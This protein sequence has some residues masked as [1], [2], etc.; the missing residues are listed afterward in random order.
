MAHHSRAAVMHH[1]GRPMELL[2]IRLADPRP[3]EVVVHTAI[4]GVCGTDL[5]FAAGRFP[6]PVPT[7]LGHEAAGTIAAVGD[8]VDHLTVGDRVIVCDQI[9]CGNCPACLS[10]SMVYCTDSG[11]K[12]R[13][14]ERLSLEGTSFRQYL[15]VSAFAEKLLVDAHACIPAP[16]D[17]PLDAAA[18]LSCCLTTGLAAV[19]NVARPAAGSRVAVIGCGGVGLG[20]VQAARI[21]GAAQIVAVDLEDHRLALAAEVGATDTVNAASTDP[22]KAVIDLADG[23]V[24]RSIEA[25]GLPETATQAFRVLAAGGNATV[26]GMM[27]PGADIAVPGRLLRQGRSI[28]GTVMG[29]VRTRSDIPR[30]AD[31]ALRGLLHTEPLITSTR[32]L[33]Q[34]D[35]SLADARARRGVRHTIEF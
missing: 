30:Y 22:V 20:A 29:S 4:A 14:R 31:L 32:P 35:H 13:Q 3:G 7:V 12:Q 27:P 15:G 21:A 1:P 19:F 25:V 5:H 23:G 2:K 10:G 11:A 34:L 28:G 16:D 9:Y 8:G 24:E 18:L 26:L 17:L 6:Y 33:D